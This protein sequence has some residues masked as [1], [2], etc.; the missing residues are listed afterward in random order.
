MIL[1]RQW[2]KD[3]YRKFY[4]ERIE[5]QQQQI[6]IC[7]HVHC[8]LHNDSIHCIYF[9]GA[10]NSDVFFQL[11]NF[12]IFQLTRTKFLLNIN[13]S[14][15]LNCIYIHIIVS[16]AAKWNSFLVFMAKRTND[17]Y[18]A[19]MRAYAEPGQTKVIRI[20]LI[21]KSIGYNVGPNES[22]CDMTITFWLPSSISHLF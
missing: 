3:E 16:V 20:L 14:W 18:Y 6:N 12:L 8:I 13:G 17:D 2:K 15:W 21:A 19:S 1:W 9:V 7:V 5:N 11:N 22:G 4:C 10:V